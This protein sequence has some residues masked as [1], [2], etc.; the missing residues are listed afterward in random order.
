MTNFCKA[1]ALCATLVVA[2]V[3]ASKPSVVAAQDKPNIVLINV[4]DADRDMFRPTIMKDRFPNIQ[5]I[6]SGGTSFTNFH[7]TT[8]V[9][10]PSRACLL[11]GQHAYALGVQVN[12]RN[13]LSARG[14][15]GDSTTF[16][17]KGFYDDELGKWMKDAGYH[18]I[19]VGKF[20][21]TMRDRIPKGWDDFYQ[22]AGSE[23]YKTVRMT[24][25]KEP[26]GGLEKLEDGV[27]RTN[28][29]ADDVVRLIQKQTENANPLFVYFAPFGPH[30]EG[31]AEGGMIDLKWKDLWP[32]IQ[33]PMDADW[34]EKDLSDKPK[35]Y[36]SIEPVTDKLKTFFATEYRERMIAMKSID[37]AV[38]RIVDA[39]RKT[40]RLGN[41]YLFFMSD[42]GYSL[43]QH[44]ISGKCSP[45]TRS[46][47]VPLLVSGPGVPKSAKRNDLLAHIDLAPTLLGLAG[48]KPKRFFDGK[49]FQT[50]LRGDA[51]KDERA[52]RDALL[53]ENWQM[54][55]FH[56][57]ALSTTY[58][59]LRMYD[60]IYT[61]W[62]DGSREFY[63]LKKDPFELENSYD[64]IASSDVER[65]SF[66][67][68]KLRTRVRAP[69]VTVENTLGRIR[70]R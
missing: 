67:L 1:Y 65:F 55:T 9:C 68:R 47:H 32:N 36:Q 29:E 50:L 21:N 51:P 20:N 52:W 18:T 17:R 41:T 30:T 57:M 12:A 15:V 39:L 62:A 53:I 46:A 24:N 6:A 16:Y 31:K 49:S 45:F 19:F 61:E 48:E 8:P 40:G 11:R 3:L 38:G 14:F 7:I 34:D 43:G 27:Y 26:L 10:G 28:A 44:R 56:G 22:S 13:R 25:R 70:Y 37:D 59:Q 35:S 42:N 23:Y 54:V 2:I 33:Q 66:R 69:I 60:S 64:E 4:D 58:S 63:D 5:A